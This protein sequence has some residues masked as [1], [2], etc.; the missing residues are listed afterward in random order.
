MSAGQ[1]IQLDLIQ[2]DVYIADSCAISPIAFLFIHDI[3]GFSKFQVSV[4]TGRYGMCS[5]GRTFKGCIGSSIGTGS[6]PY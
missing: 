2:M 5:L 1:S 4:Q 6:V 3:Q